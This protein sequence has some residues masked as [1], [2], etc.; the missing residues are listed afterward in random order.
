M[1]KIIKANPKRTEN[2]TC[3]IY[4][5]VFLG[6]M[7]SRYG[8]RYK[9][10]KVYDRCEFCIQNIKFTLRKTREGRALFSATNIRPTMYCTSILTAKV[11]ENDKGK[12]REIIHNLAQLLTLISG[13]Q[14]G[15][16]YIIR[17]NKTVISENK[18][19][20][21]EPFCSRYPIVPIQTKRYALKSFIE[22]S[23]DGYIANKKPYNLDRLIHL[24]LLSCI[25]RIKEIRFLTSCILIE[26]LK[27][28][29][30][31][32]VRKFK[33]NKRGYFVDSDCNE[34]TFASLLRLLGKQFGMNIDTS[35][36][37]IRNEIIH[38]GIVENPSIDLSDAWAKLM[39]HIN[40]LLLKIIGY[41][42]IYYKLNRTLSMKEANLK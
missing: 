36:I 38:Q 31:K 13:Q 24:H 12:V 26:S 17:M 11:E 40:R 9:I 7:I 22:S 18:S 30:A 8:N 37:K 41:K 2:F 20:Q 28:H 35:F 19:S 16:S 42:G 14:V 4:N 1:P 6:D 10:R 5:L 21:I 3:K 29:F 34:L 39:N 25:A 32:Y 23:Y 27:Y 15:Y 33:Q